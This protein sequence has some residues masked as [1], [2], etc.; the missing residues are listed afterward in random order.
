MGCLSCYIATIGKLVLLVKQNGKMKLA[1]NTASKAWMEPL[2]LC[3]V[4]RLR[5]QT[6]YRGEACY[7]FPT[8]RSLIHLDKL[9]SAL[10]PDKVSPKLKYCTQD[11]A[12]NTENRSKQGK[13]E[14][15][16]RSM[17][18]NLKNTF[19]KA[20]KID[21]SKEELDKIKDIKAIHRKLNDREKQK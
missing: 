1:L 6:N 17:M 11:D 16:R 10:P 2:F 7:P 8:P 14:K 4:Y 20:A 18:E 5:S 21:A 19:T 3:Q 9:P 13:I 15:N 12:V